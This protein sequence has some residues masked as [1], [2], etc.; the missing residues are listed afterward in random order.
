MSG[1][2]SS[3]P[4][5]ASNRRSFA[6]AAAAGGLWSRSCCTTARF[7]VA[8]TTGFANVRVR[9]WLRC[10]RSAKPARSRS[11]RSDLTLGLRRRTALARISLRKPAYSCVCLLWSELVPE[12]HKRLFIP[13]RRGRP[14]AAVQTPL[15]ASRSDTRK[16][17]STR[18]Q[19]RNPLRFDRRVHA[20]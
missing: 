16:C 3:R 10:T 17:G 12:R 1:T 19:I 5:D 9:S 14:P 6:T 2:S 7:A 4:R 20:E 18:L 11:R 8:D 13:W 15:S